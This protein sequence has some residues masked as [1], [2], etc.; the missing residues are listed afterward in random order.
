MSWR[1][2]RET[3]RDRA[4]RLGGARWAR[5]RRRE[6]SAGQRIRQSSLSLCTADIGGQVI[7]CCGDCPVHC[8]M[9]SRF[10]SFYPLDASSI[11]LVVATKNVSR[12]CQMS[13][14][15]QNRPLV[16]DTAIG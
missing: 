10:P 6:P 14:G 5:A 8:R 13:S 3:V 1:G 15:G 9:L 12:L 2:E 4:A 16:E 11:P 7:L